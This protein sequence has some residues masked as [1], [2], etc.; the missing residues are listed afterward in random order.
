MIF[1]E[2]LCSY[3]VFT[4]GEGKGKKGFL[5]DETFQMRVQVTG[6]E[7]DGDALSIVLGTP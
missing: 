5:C 2:I 1:P 4:E 6:G 3:L 7:G